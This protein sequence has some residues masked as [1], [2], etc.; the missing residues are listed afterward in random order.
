MITPSFLKY[1]KLE[2]ESLCSNKCI[3]WM[4]KSYIIKLFTQIIYSM[5]IGSPWSSSTLSSIEMCM[6]KI[7]RSWHFVHFF[8]HWLKKNDQLLLIQGSKCDFIIYVLMIQLPHSQSIKF[9]R[10][11]NFFSSLYIF[12]LEDITQIIAFGC[13]I[14]SKTFSV[15][16]PLLKKLIYR[17]NVFTCKMA[18]K[19]SE[20]TG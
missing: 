13:F 4:Q 11:N 20:K 3:K 1:V 6:N 5:V 18:D 9:F 15:L 7:R 12:M 17:K 19:S 10:T 16:L 8:I 14:T 2:Y